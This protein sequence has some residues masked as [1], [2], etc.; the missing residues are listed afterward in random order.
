M[1]DGSV[2][3]PAPVEHL[4]PVEGFA[5]GDEQNAR[6]TFKTVEWDPSGDLAKNWLNKRG[7]Q[8]AT[9]QQDGAVRFEVPSAHAEAAREVIDT[10]DEK[11]ENFDK[12]GRT[13]GVWKLTDSNTVGEDKTFTYSAEHGA[14][15]LTATTEGRWTVA[16]AGE[17]LAEGQAPQGGLNA[18]MVKAAATANTIRD[19][20]KLVKG[21]DLGK[22]L[23]A[24]SSDRA[25]GSPSLAQKPEKSVALNGRDAVVRAAERNAEQPKVDSPKHT[26]GISQ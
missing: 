22:G 8:F 26:K 9:E 5:E 20:K 2:E 24:P 25:Q 21:V 16:C 14:F 6:F 12:I 3:A 15:D 19:E 7:V 17:P 10:L 11:I 18:A 13:D 1:A 4:E 23:G